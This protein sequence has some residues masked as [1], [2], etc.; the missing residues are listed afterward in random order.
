MI[1]FGVHTLTNLTFS[2][3]HFFIQ[4]GFNSFVVV[5]FLIIFI[6]YFNVLIERNTTLPLLNKDDNNE[7]LLT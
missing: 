6:F 5:S 2:S 3:F 1:S 7:E 4:W